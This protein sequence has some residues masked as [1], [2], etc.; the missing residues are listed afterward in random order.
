MT[1][2]LPK[3]QWNLILTIILRKRMNLCCVWSWV[4]ACTSPQK[5]LTRLNLMQQRVL[6]EILTLKI[7]RVIETLLIGSECMGCGNPS[8]FSVLSNS[9]PPSRDF[10]KKQFFNKNCDK[11]ISKINC[12]SML[13]T[14]EFPQSLLQQR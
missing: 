3:N 5:K 1:K 12:F 10:L 13:G 2:K 11:Y 6:G 14:L 8:L 7:S 4:R 9:F